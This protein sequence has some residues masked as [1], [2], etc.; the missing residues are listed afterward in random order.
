MFTSNIQD[1]V[2]AIFLTFTCFCGKVRSE[3]LC[4][5]LFYK[6]NS[7][8]FVFLHFYPTIVALG[9]NVIH[10]MEITK[11]L[12]LASSVWMFFFFLA[13]INLSTGA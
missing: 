7:L 2:A 10:K 4:C 5:V 13:C 1:M 6:G 11:D 9:S 12:Y 8:D 3:F